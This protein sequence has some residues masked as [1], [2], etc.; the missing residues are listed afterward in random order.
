LGGRLPTVIYQ[1]ALAAG[2]G[3]AFLAAAGIM[4]AALVIAIA[5][6]HADVRGPEISARAIDR[7]RGGD[8]QDSEWRLGAVVRG[9]WR[10]K[11]LRPA[12]PGSDAGR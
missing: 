10:R 4:L 1:H 9:Q 3:R 7:G 11:A 8:E 6:I 5:R 12:E 2:F